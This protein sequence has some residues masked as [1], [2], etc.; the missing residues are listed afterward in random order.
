MKTHYL[1]IAT[2]DSRAVAVCFVEGA[3]WFYHRKC[4]GTTRNE[5]FLNAA[6]IKYD[7]VALLEDIDEPTRVICNSSYLVDGMNRHMKVWSVNQFKNSKGEP[8][9]HQDLWV[10][11]YRLQKRMGDSVQWVY[12]GNCEGVKRATAK[13]ASF[14]SNPEWR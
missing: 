11:L 2:G 14:I 8:L 7:H 3:T 5:A 6:I 9:A 4:T 1:A 12:D 13:A 10:E